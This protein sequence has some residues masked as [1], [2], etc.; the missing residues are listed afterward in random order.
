MA[1]KRQEAV[2]NDETEVAG[3]SGKGSVHNPGYDNAG[4]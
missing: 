1:G 2:Q 4:D 3:F